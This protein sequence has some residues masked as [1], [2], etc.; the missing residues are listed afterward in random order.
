MIPHLAAL[1]VPSALFLTTHADTDRGVTY[2][3]KFE[4]GCDCHR[5]LD[6]A[7]GVTV[8]IHGEARRYVFHQQKL[9]PEDDRMPTYYFQTELKRWKLLNNS[10]E[11]VETTCCKAH[12]IRLDRSARIPTHANLDLASGAG[13]VAAI[14]LNP[15]EERL[16]K[17]SASLTR[18]PAWDV[19]RFDRNRE[20][21]PPPP[22]HRVGDGLISVAEPIVQPQRSVTQEHEPRDHDH[23]QY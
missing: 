6:A 9:V 4:G 1:L 19:R 3:C 7:G 21:G 17:S 2:T 18:R 12:R 23:K 5:P 15:G 11:T 20:T 14:T 22:L 10:G 13:F 16:L 8:Q